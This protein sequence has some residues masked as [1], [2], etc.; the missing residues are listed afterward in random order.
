MKDSKPSVLAQQIGL[1]TAIPFVLLIGPALGYA[2][3]SLMDGWWRSS[4]WGMGGGLVLG[5][6]A[7]ARTTMQLIR[8]ARNLG[9]N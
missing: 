1:L 3:G 4:P 2:V 9:T 7:S 5:F 6:A 8:R